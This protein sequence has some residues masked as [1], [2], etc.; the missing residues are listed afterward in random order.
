MR[1][2]KTRAQTDKK[3]HP[4]RGIHDNGTTNHILLKDHNKAFRDSDP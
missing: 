3:N 2:R 4:I 1:G